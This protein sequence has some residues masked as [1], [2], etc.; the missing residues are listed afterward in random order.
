MD[1]H[2]A[3]APYKKER[4]MRQLVIAIAVMLCLCTVHAQKSP[5]TQQTPFDATS[6]K[7]APNFQGHD[8]RRVASAV[9]SAKLKKDE[10]E[11]TEAFQV[12]LA[13]VLGKPVF[14]TVAI[15]DQLGLLRRSRLEPETKYDADKRTLSVRVPVNGRGTFI[16]GR[17][18]TADSLELHSSKENSYVGSN[19]Y[20]ATRRVRKVESTSCFVAFPSPFHN[21]R[22]PLIVEIPDVEPDRARRLNGQ[23]DVLYVGKLAEPYLSEVFDHSA[24]TIDYPTEITVKGTALVIDLGAIWVIHRPTGDVLHKQTY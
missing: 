6:T 5:R 23:I 2:A 13:G 20:G 7:L 10:Y 11:T 19:A 16:N 12:R 1:W 21:V 14:G 24:A 4:G 22:D 17:P 9:Q 18:F 3:A 8:C 15:G